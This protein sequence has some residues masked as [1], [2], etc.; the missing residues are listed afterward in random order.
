MRRLLPLVLAALALAA[1]GC[2]SS[3]QANGYVNDVNRAQKSFADRISELTA[4]VSA[5]STPEQDRRVLDRYGQAVDEVVGRLRGLQPPDGV[6]GLHDELIGEI[7][8]YGTTVGRFRR[9]LT[10][11]D[12]R[13]VLDAQAA[14]QREASSISASVNRT[15]REID[16][17]LRG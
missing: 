4:G 17:E 6:A 2:S 5:T 13:A 15:L 10:S 8:R 16:R 3:E 7:G 11:S 12:P 1:A 14:F 9:R